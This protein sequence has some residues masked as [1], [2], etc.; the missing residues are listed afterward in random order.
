MPT[1]QKIIQLYPN[2]LIKKNYKFAIFFISMISL[3]ILSFIMIISF[4]TTLTSVTDDKGDK[5]YLPPKYIFLYLGIAFSIFG[6]IFGGIAL[7]IFY[8]IFGFEKS[9]TFNVLVGG[10]VLEFIFL[11]IEIILI[12]KKYNFCPDG[13]TFDT[14]LKKCVPICQKGTQLDISSNTCVPFCNSKEDCNGTDCV[15]QVCCPQDRPMN[16]NG[17]CCKPEN[18]KDNYCCANVVCIGNDGKKSCCSADEKCQGGV[19]KIECPP[20][21]DNYCDAGSTCT[22]FDATDKEKY[23]DIKF[24]C[25]ETYCYTCQNFNKSCS[26]TGTPYFFPGDLESA[27]YPASIYPDDQDFRDLIL[28][29]DH[30]NEKIGDLE[31]IAKSALPDHIGLYC[32][33][34][35][36]DV[37]RLISIPYVG[38]TCE[39]SLQFDETIETDKIKT[40]Y[41]S[42]VQDAGDQNKYWVNMKLSYKDAQQQSQNMTPLTF[43]DNGKGYYTFDKD[44]DSQ[45]YKWNFHPFKNTSPT[46]LYQLST[47]ASHPLDFDPDCN[48]FPS[49]SWE[50]KLTA[51][52]EFPLQGSSPNQIGYVNNKPDLFYSKG[53][54]TCADGS[55][56]KCTD[57][58]CLQCTTYAC[59]TC[60]GV[61]SYK[62]DS[63]G[64]KC[65]IDQFPQQPCNDP[66]EAPTKI[67]NYQTCDS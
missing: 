32:G 4:I 5:Y 51:K 60:T 22:R 65:G 33:Q 21:S 23:P 6:L 11:I 54:V 40:D 58:R 19:C 47:N 56:I 64:C 17:L 16:C 62:G 67:G 29:N 31:E 55:G 46:S 42:F 35:V 9:G 7:Y 12:T 30:S 28:N 13:Q 37:Y 10:L 43:L 57:K 34:N 61:F 39:A 18:C 44:P 24:N 3:T 15:G 2:Q 8:R 63:S 50:P 36:P 59:D 49:D 20:D 52:Y 25:D 14:E 53:T 38:T 41:T 27:F 66:K 1:N 45:S 48:K 26:Q